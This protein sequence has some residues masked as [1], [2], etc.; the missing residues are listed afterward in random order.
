MAPR[1][2]R[3]VTSRR[4]DIPSEHSERVASQV[5]SV[6]NL[7]MPRKN[8]SSHEAKQLMIQAV[9]SSTVT[10]APPHLIVLRILVCGFT[11]AVYP[12]GAGDLNSR[13]IK[14]LQQPYKIQTFYWP[15]IGHVVHF[16]VI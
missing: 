5:G 7:M 8:S 15:L 3:G 4:A 9:S 12:G 13:S 11:R 16:V 6:C 1:P 2:P 14:D 10:A